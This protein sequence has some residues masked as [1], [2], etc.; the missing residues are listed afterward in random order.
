MI[1]KTSNALTHKAPTLWVNLD[2]TRIPVAVPSLDLTEKFL[3]KAHAVAELQNGLTQ[4]AYDGLFEFFADL[5]SCNH[6]YRRFTPE[7]LKAKNI[8][9]EQIIGVLADWAQFIGALA[10]LKN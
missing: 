8:T 1:T 10:S 5:L 6:N 4:E 3:E 9:V 2:D 7:E